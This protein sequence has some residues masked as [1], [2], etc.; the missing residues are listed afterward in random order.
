MSTLTKLPHELLSLLL[1]EWVT[2]VDAA[3]LD[4]AFCSS[5]DR[6]EFVIVAYSSRATTF[7][8]PTEM[9]PESD[10]WRWAL[11]PMNAW[12]MRKNAPVNGV[13]ASGGILREHELRNDFMDKCGKNIKW[14]DCTQPYWD[15][16]NCDD[17][18]TYE[19]HAQSIAD[20]VERCPN[21]KKLILS[22]CCDETTLEWIAACCPLLE[23][24]RI[25]DYC[26]T[27]S[28]IALVEHFTGLR[29][30]QIGVPAVTEDEL[31]ELVRR[32]PRLLSLD[33]S[34][35][36]PVSKLLRAVSL[37]CSSLAEL[38]IRGPCNTLLDALHALLSHCGQLRKLKLFG[39]KFLPMQEGHL[40]AAYTA[41]QELDLRYV[42]LPPG[43]LDG[44]LRACSCLT[45]LV[46][47]YLFGRPEIGPFMVGRHCRSLEEIEISFNE[48]ETRWA[49]NPILLDIGKNCPR[50]RKLHIKLWRPMRLKG[51]DG[52][53]A[54]AKLCPMLEGVRVW[55]GASV[56][57][58]VRALAAECTQLRHVVLEDTAKSGLHN[59]SLAALV[60]ANSGLLSCAIR[61]SG[62]VLSQLFH[63]LG[64][65][66][67]GLQCQQLRALRCSGCTFFPS[68]EPYHL[69][70]PC[71]SMRELHLT[72]AT[73]P[74][75][76]LEYL[77]HACP[78]LTQLE[79]VA[80]SCTAGR[81]VLI[82]THCPAL[83]KLSW[84]GKNASFDGDATMLNVSE[85]CSD[86]RELEI[87]GRLGQNGAGIAA[88][89][90]RCPRL[91]QLHI[92]EGYG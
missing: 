10:D 49:C 64:G 56:D 43:A 18:G 50:L 63:A 45:R 55:G 31:L 91:Q 23:D 25:C 35:Q 84:S 7:H 17:N 40:P 24:L 71:S 66:C 67:T 61:A 42:Q 48:R 44:L 33:V 21:L 76:A 47:L 68:T 77:L 37:S 4:S 38:S 22:H 19:D 80:M 6:K 34:I 69:S 79:A 29:H 13:F 81:S 78:S 26:E 1:S 36:G 90:R 72:D 32:N 46:S 30:V 51:T 53:V 41:M 87:G 52:M 75:G 9:Y 70:A 83:Q 58:A 89:A 12:I 92:E 20:I 27:E 86:L 59:S 85:H 57:V 14:A 74:P 28:I 39:P 73:L 88:V 3:R 62:T 15:H 54:V 82:G 16:A 5:M 8:Y 60:R 11:G 2:I 65:T